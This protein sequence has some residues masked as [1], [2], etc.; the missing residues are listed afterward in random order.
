MLGLETNIRFL[1]ALLQHERVRAGEIDT[2]LIETMLPFATLDPDEGVLAA[3]SRAAIPPGESATP[4]GGFTADSRC[5]RGNECRLES[6][7]LL[8]ET[9][10]EHE[11]TL[12]SDASVVVVQEPTVEGESEAAPAFWAG[13]TVP[14]G[15]L[16]CARRGANARRAY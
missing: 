11:A 4:W 9:G 2:G 5:A 1:R 8:D 13:E 3:V 14:R 6:F 15:A 12:G 16:W 10:A 7:T